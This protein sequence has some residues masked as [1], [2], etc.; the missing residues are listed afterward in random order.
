MG[1]GVLQ[2]DR[3]EKRVEW[4]ESALFSPLISACEGNLPV[5]KNIL[6]YG[7]GYLVLKGFP[8]NRPEAEYLAEFEALAGLIGEPQGHGHSG[9][10]SWRISPRASLDHVPTFSE[11]ASEAPLHTDNSWVPEPEKYFSLLAVRPAIDGGESIVL[12]LE[13]VLLGFLQKPQGREA[14]ALLSQPLFPFAVPDVFLS[15]EEFAAPERKALVF[16]VFGSTVGF[17]FRHDAIR[18]GFAQRPE[19]ASSRAEWA[20]EF[21]NDY[22]IDFSERTPKVKL[23]SGDVLIANNHRVLHARTDFSD[24]NRLLWRARMAERFR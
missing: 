23:E 4:V 20:I 21:F 7:C 11:M 13:Q 19:L 12:P 1:C 17:R 18:R 14:W 10:K 24:S 6:D 15:E 3:L 16:P 8:L 22:L 9:K 2:K 5:I